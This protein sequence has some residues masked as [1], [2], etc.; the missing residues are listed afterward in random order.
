MDGLPQ[1]QQEPQLVGTT[2]DIKSQNSK[3][4]KSHFAID[5]LADTNHHTE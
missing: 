1:R 4:Q 2:H 3:T 5:G